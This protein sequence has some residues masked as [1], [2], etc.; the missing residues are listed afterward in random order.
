[1]DTPL[2]LYAPGGRMTESLGLGNTPAPKGHFIYTA[3]NINRTAK[4]GIAD[5]PSESSG[6]TRPSS[7][8]WYAGRVWYAGIDHPD[9]AS[10]V[11]Y[12]QIIEGND[13]FG[14]CYQRNDPTSEHIFALLDTDGGTLDLPL[15]GK[16]LSMRVVGD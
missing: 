10:T 15:V 1:I 2:P 13:Q 4:T 3:W 9:Y 16:V 14:E 12:S 8:V 11:Y 7:I 6:N 5:L